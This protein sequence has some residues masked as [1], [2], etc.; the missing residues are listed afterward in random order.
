MELVHAIQTSDLAGVKKQ[1]EE[2]PH[3][4]NDRGMGGASPLHWAAEVFE[5]SIWLEQTSPSFLAYFKYGNVEIVKELLSRGGNPLIL[6][7]SGKK[8]EGDKVVM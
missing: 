7:D 5:S 3:L 4:I 8:E 1:L 6:D 2:H